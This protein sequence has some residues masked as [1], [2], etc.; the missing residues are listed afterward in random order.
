MAL[1]WP[2]KKVALDIVDLPGR[3]PPEQ[4]EKE[5]WKILKVTASQMND[6]RTCKQIMACI[7]ALLG[8][9]APLRPD[10]DEQNLRVSQV[11]DRLCA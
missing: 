6:F 11:F 9:D 3:R 10:W 5:G 4:E 7:A 1:C 2:D 8:S